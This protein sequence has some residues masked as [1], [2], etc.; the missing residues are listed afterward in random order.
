MLHREGFQTFLQTHKKPLEYVQ[1]M[2]FNTD[3]KLYDVCVPD[4]HS[5]AQFLHQSGHFSTLIRIYELLPEISL[6]IS[7]FQS[8]NAIEVVFGVNHRKLLFLLQD[9]IQENK[10]YQLYNSHVVKNNLQH[11]QWLSTILPFESLPPAFKKELWTSCA[12]LP[13]DTAVWLWSKLNLENSMLFRPFSHYYF[14][15]RFPY[16]V[17]EKLHFDMDLLQ[18]EEILSIEQ[19]RSQS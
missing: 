19:H 4:I 6:P 11:L 15:Q 18:D 1:N 16:Y 12:F 17:F 14:V 2:L 7:Y 5:F 8:V 13:T 9:Y 10:L 3:R